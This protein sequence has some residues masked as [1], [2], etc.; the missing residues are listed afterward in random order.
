MAKV[1]YV[2]RQAGSSLRRNFTL[3][4]ASLLT[5][6]VSLTLVGLSLLMQ[7]GVSNSTR[8]WSGGVEFIVFM[9][10]DA[11]QDQLDAVNR[12]LL[13]N[14]QV[15]K[16]TFFTKQQAYAEFQKYYP[17]APELTQ[18]L[19]VEQMPPSFRVVPKVA[20]ENVIEA[21]GNQFDKKPGVYN[22]S[23][24]K[25]SVEWIRQISEFLKWGSYVFA[26][27]LGFV[28]IVLI[29]NTIRTAM[30]AR[31]REVEV[32][33][34]VGAT[35]WFIRLPFML[36]GLVQGLVG[37]AVACLGI[38]GVN[39]LWETKVI[40]NLSVAEL[41]ALVVTSGQLQFTCIVVLLAGTLVGAAGSGF[42][43]TRFLDV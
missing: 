9:N 34:L 12:D 19:T 36:E 13:Q 38:I 4:A 7:N 31:R 6:V 18:V 25:K 8:R 29:W 32:M 40:D 17:D 35:N 23:Y 28:A 21:I 26:A 15:S 1:S 22:V 33:K 39:W 41:K 14:P 5:V 3:T 37:A 2:V 42:A 24:A 27:V 10:P 20:D 30:F 16:V 43:V 11:T